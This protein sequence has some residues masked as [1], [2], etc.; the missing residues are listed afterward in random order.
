MRICVFGG[1]GFLGRHLVERLTTAGHEVVVPSRD[2]ARHRDLLVLPGVRLTQA[3]F[4]APLAVRR[5]VSG[6]DTVVNLV[7]ILHERREGDFA[8]VHVDIPRRIAEAC[9]FAEV[10]RLLH[11]S[12]LNASANAPS[13]YLRSKWQ[14][15]AAVAGARVA[16]TVFRPSVLFGAG[17]SF[18]TRFASLVD[19]APGFFPLPCSETRLAPLHVADLVRAIVRSLDARQSFGATYDLCGPVVYSLRQWVE[20]IAALKG[21]RVRVIGLGPRA[22]WLQALLLERLPGRPLTRDSYRS[23]LLDSVCPSPWPP[24][25]APPPVPPTEIVPSY[26]GAAASG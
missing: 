14:G 23:L 11:V 25:F 19:F 5:Q 1:S 9:E 22:S 21:R 7:G 26:I 10:P 8:R 16:S 24:L 6:M 17:D 4:H 3:D 2:P 18:S 12:A 15:E 13:R 20:Y